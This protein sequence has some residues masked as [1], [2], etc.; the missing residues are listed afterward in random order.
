MGT[1]LF[2]A[3][4][5]LYESREKSRDWLV[6][7]DLEGAG[8]V[9]VDLRRAQ[10]LTPVVV[11]VEGEGKVVGEAVVSP[12]EI[13]DD[14]FSRVDF[15]RVVART[16]ERVKF[17][18][19]A[20][21][22][23]NENAVGV[24]FDLDSGE[25]AL[26]AGE[27][28]TGAERFRLWV[29]DNPQSAER[30]GFMVLGGLALAALLRL[31]EYQIKGI[32][33]AVIGMMIL[34]ATTFL[35]RVPTAIQVD[36][37]F[38]GDAFN[39]L[40]KSKAWIGG[41]D[42]FAAD[43]RKAPLMPLLLIPGFLPGFD[44]L[45]W[46]RAVSMVASGVTTVLVV[47]LGKR[48]GVPY[49]LAFGAGALL[50]VNRE[51]WWESIQG[52][53]N[54]V[55]TLVIVAAVV[56]FA[57]FKKPA[58]RYWTAILAALSALARYEGV[59]VAAVLV[60]FTWWEAQWSKNTIFRT[61]AG[62]A[63]ILVI[64]FLMWPIT[65]EAGVRTPGDIAGDGGLYLVRS[66][67]DLAG[68]LKMLA[69]FWGRAWLLVPLVGNPGEW[70]VRGA[71]LSGWL[72]V[73]L[74]R[75]IAQTEM[76][77]YVSGIKVILVWVLYAALVGLAGSHSTEYDKLLVQIISLFMGGAMVAWLFRQPR[78]AGPVILMLVIQTIVITAMLPK[79]RYFLPLLPFMSLIIV[80]GIY[81]ISGW[82]QSR[83]GRI[84]SLGLTAA[85]VMLV[86]TDTRMAL[87]G[88]VSDYNEKSAGLTVLT[89]AARWLSEEGGEV[90][91]AEDRDLP[92]RVYLSKERL[93]TVKDTELTSEEI[94]EMLRAKRANLVLETDFDPYFM[95]VVNK[96]PD[97]FKRVAEFESG[98]SDKKARVYAISQTKEK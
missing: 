2:E 37:A 22:A 86:Y 59:L 46:G 16:G 27:R 52:L 76:A 64:P 13:R 20:P 23:R 87:P 31:M 91:V 66:A 70:L 96:Y 95:A 26:E 69:A 5:A 77:K 24:R 15:G 47:L 45:W 58:G 75:A 78:L 7:E 50:A 33:L 54:T 44:P 92:A 74:S 65:G 97:Q 93:V 62:A 39:Y 19:S 89:A 3:H 1:D 8:F 51:F 73:F 10:D 41:E 4:H 71:L 34:V 21:Q 63:I 83:L 81:L 60:P 17:T 36:S 6:K 57:Y 43:F 90:I 48:M 79:S 72:L 56:G 61:M 85:L 35:I 25:L 29:V 32:K 98:Y 38:G 68:N 18:V 42:P 84:G 80:Y 40:L 67:D 53:A 11:K 30:V 82:Y 49:P 55:Y 9:L 12:N 88:V 14:Q 94:L 28:V